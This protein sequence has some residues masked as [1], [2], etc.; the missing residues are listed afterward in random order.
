MTGWKGKTIYIDLSS[1]LITV[2]STDEELIRR[3]IGGRGL[4]VKLLS[5]LAKPDI[6]PL[7]P[8]NPLVFT[9]GPLTGLV[10]MSSGA[11]ITSKSPLTGTVF[12]WNA[13]GGFGRELRKAE[14][15]ALVIIG[16]AGSPSFVEIRGEE[17]K[18]AHAGSLWGK[19][20]QKHVL[21]P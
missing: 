14:I 12:S 7:S 1:G 11:V 16:K 4:G 10:P 21:M 17:I 3:Y 8:E 15:D 19:K 5:E 20:T 6:D 9:S 13:G 18:I 2:K